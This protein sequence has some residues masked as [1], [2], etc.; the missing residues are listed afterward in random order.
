[1]LWYTVNNYWHKGRYRGYAHS[2][3]GRVEVGT[4]GFTAHRLF[5][6]HAPGTT[7]V[8]VASGVT[9]FDS[10]EAAGSVGRY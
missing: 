2:G 7:N 5:S 1:V 4:R 8:R 10:S 3:I 9:C 6:A